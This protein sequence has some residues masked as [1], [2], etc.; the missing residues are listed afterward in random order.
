[1]VVVFRYPKR[2]CQISLQMVASHHGCWDLNSGPLEEQSVLLTTEPSLQPPRAYF[3]KIV[4]Y[5]KD[6]LRHPAWILTGFLHLP[7][8]AIVELAGP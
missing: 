4:M 7:W 5:T 3:Y 8:V 6:Q 2:G 1:M